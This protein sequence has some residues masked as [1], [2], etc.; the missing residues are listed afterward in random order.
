MRL[1]DLVP[2]ASECVTM[3]DPVLRILGEMVPSSECRTHLKRSCDI[4]DICYHDL[5]LASHPVPKP[6]SRD[7][8]ITSSPAL[9]MM[10]GRK[11][12]FSVIPGS[13][14]LAQ[15]E[16]DPFGLAPALCFSEFQGLAGLQMGKPIGS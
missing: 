15:L 13:E 1:G 10:A 4:E 6:Q 14:S 2:G 3:G 5:H 11:M 8:I 9:E 16:T 7:L 12:D